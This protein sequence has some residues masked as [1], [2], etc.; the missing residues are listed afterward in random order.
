MPTD[1]KEVVEVFEDPYPYLIQ[2]L[3]EAV[4]DGH[5]VR[6]RQLVPQDQGQIVD[7]ERQRPAHFPL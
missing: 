7:G 4:E 3:E 1:L 2:V 5:Q 6:C